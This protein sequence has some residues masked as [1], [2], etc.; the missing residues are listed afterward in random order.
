MSVIFKS[1]EKLKG[2]SAGDRLRDRQLQRKRG[3]QSSRKTILSPVTV[4]SFLLVLIPAI[5]GVQY[6][7]YSYKKHYSIREKQKYLSAKN[8]KPHTVN[9]R[10]R[11][12][13]SSEKV[14]PPAQEARGF[15]TVG[16]ED[17]APVSQSTDLKAFLPMPSEV[18]YHQGSP[19]TSDQVRNGAN[20]MAFLPRSF[21]N[22]H[23]SPLY[24]FIPKEGGK[25]NINDNSGA[26]LQDMGQDSGPFYMDLPPVIREQTG[27]PTT[28]GAFYE[29]TV[30]SDIF[31]NPLL[32]RPGGLAGDAAELSFIESESQSAKADK[33]HV[34]NI[35]KSRKATRLV[36]KINRAIRDDDYDHVEKLLDQLA[37]LKGNENSYVMKL[38]AFWLLKQED[39][40]SAALILEKVL[41][42]DENDME[43]GIN[44]AV[45][46]V[47]N[48]KQPDAW[49]RLLKLKEIYPDNTLIPELMEKLEKK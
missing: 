49:E 21:E 44:M 35:E 5:Y 11:S 48:D 7:I 3:Q 34:A 47:N 9:T 16:K 12:A 24:S 25:M 30:N 38:K 2:Q 19:P 18:K 31:E 28:N 46:E 26:D 43:A 10:N 8:K 6:G 37:V 40:D 23:A 27:I 33:I 1:L 17:K 42:K 14:H 41:E 36:S 45:V 39:Y 32:K 13:K 4:I 29:S 22:D 20:N 15:E